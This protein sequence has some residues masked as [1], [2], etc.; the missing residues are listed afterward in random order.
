MGGEEQ[1][2]EAEVLSKAQRIV[3][4]LNNHNLRSVNDQNE[5]VLI[6]GYAP[7]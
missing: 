4:E 7:W 2:K 6:L 5:F 1:Q 3:L